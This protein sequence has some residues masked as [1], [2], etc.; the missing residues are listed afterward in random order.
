MNFKIIK[1]INITIR[2]IN[3]LFFWIAYIIFII[4]LWFGNMDYAI[5]FLILGAWLNI[6]MKIEDFK[7][8]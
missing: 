7:N 3:R 1:D 2:T 5:L 6:E 4:N 8:N